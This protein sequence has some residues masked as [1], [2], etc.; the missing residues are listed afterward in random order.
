MIIIFIIINLNTSHPDK[1]NDITF[2]EMCENNINYRTMHHHCFDLN[3]VKELHEY[4]GFE[5]INCFC[6]E[7]DKLQLIYFGRLK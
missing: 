5:T 1:P 3:L 7:Y 6:P 2:K 4:L